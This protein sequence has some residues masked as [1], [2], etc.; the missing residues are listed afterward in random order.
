MLYRSTARRRLARFLLAGFVLLQVNNVLFRHAHRLPDGRIIVHAH[1]Y[2]L[3]GK[4]GP[5]LPNNHSASEL[6]LL[7][8]LTHA[9]FTPAAVAVFTALLLGGAQSGRPISALL[10][11]P[12]HRPFTSF[13]HRGPPVRLCLIA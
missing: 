7:D 5:V 2:N 3:F 10:P 6:R 1:P 4:G 11:A 9:V 12:V 13:A 8:L